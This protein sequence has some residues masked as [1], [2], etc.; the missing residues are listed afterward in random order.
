[1]LLWLNVNLAVDP[2]YRIRSNKF[3]FAVCFFDTWR[4]IYKSVLI[5]NYTFSEKFGKVRLTQRPNTRGTF[6]LKG[7]NRL[8]QTMEILRFKAALGLLP[9]VDDYRFT[10]RTLGKFQYKTLLFINHSEE[11]QARTFEVWNLC[12]FSKWVSASHQTLPPPLIEIEKTLRR[13]FSIQ[14]HLFKTQE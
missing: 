8:A 6:W 10:F 1:M 13:Q 14:H 9:D 3:S 11:T 7:D 4:I 12:S 5:L 2:F